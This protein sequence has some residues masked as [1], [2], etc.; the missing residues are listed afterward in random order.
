MF[1]YR[2]FSSAGRIALVAG[3]PRA[4]VGIAFG[5]FRRFVLLLMPYDAKQRGLRSYGLAISRAAGLL[6]LAWIRIRHPERRT[7]T[8]G[9]QYPGSGGPL[10]LGLERRY[11]SVRT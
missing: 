11:G 2:E 7:A 3:T 10:E 1:L 5:H 4:V 9:Y 6:R 8:C